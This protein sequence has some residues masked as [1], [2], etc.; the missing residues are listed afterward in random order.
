LESPGAVVPA[1][2]TTI[3]GGGSVLTEAGI[4][5]ETSLIAAE[6]SA[7]IESV[8]GEFNGE[9]TCESTVGSTAVVSDIRIAPET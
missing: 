7:E 1:S 4:E 5:L 6:F 3:T 2:G 8:K 9:A